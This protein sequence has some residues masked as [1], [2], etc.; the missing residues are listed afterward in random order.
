MEL[1]IK[2]EYTI[3]LSKTHFETLEID[4]DEYLKGYF[5]HIKNITEQDLINAINDY[6]WQ[7]SELY[8]CPEDINSDFEEFAYSI[9]NIKEIVKAYEYLINDSMCKHDNESGIYCSKCGVKLK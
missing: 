3:T 2:S 4:L 9:M 1:K 5:E 6:R 7:I 8:V